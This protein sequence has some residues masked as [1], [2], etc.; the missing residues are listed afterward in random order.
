[1]SLRKIEHCPLDDHDG[2]QNPGPI[3][4]DELDCQEIPLTRRSDAD[5]AVRKAARLAALET[6]SSR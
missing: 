2:M 1:V 6:L 5:H 3:A 4:L